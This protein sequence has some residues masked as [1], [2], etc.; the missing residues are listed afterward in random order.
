MSVFGSNRETCTVPQGGRARSSPGSH[1]GVDSLTHGPA[2]PL[3]P[4]RRSLPTSERDRAT[5]TPGPNLWTRLP[6]PFF[7]LAPMED[8]TD[9][10]FRRFIAGFGAPDVFFT[11]FLRCDRAASAEADR[12]PPRLVHTQN[13]RPL[14]AQ[15]WGTRPG[16][17]AAAASN[18]ERLGFDGI[19][20][21]MGCPVKKIRKHGACSALIDNPTLAA[22]LI[23]AA[24]EA[25]ALP[26]SV[27]TRIGLA[28]VVTEEWI[29]LLLEQTPAAITI[30]PR[31]ADQ[32]SDGEADWSQVALAVRLRD[33]IAPG[34]VILGNGDVV[35]VEQGRRLA[36][37]TGAEGLM[38]GRG[39]FRNPFAFSYRPVRNGATGRTRFA[40]T[41]NSDV[42]IHPDRRME[43]M[44]LTERVRYLRRHIAA[45]QLQW[46]TS[47]N[48]EALKKFYRN[49]IWGGPAAEA[50]LVRLYETHD[51]DEALSVLDSR[52]TSSDRRPA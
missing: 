30:H 46:G 21:N 29:G 49:W 16:E 7:A 15:I 2:Q 14:V 8:V 34:T 45:F 22:E 6:R 1:S 4:N 17:I 47:R 20:L 51:Y 39:V 19:D 52:T 18:L 3:P 33:R 23:A 32:M 41:T 12:L 13:E 35:T 5:V 24:K 31:T 25:T 50:L 48:Y 44:P 10:V 38:I 27:K 9:T 26:V 40:W 42:L 36:E 11:E 37:E 28:G 43:G